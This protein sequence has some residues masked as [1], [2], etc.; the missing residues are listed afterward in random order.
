MHVNKCGVRDAD[1]PDAVTRERRLWGRQA[2]LAK[3]AMKILFA[4]KRSPNAPAVKINAAN[5]IV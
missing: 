5:A 4:P 1:R 2:W 3:P